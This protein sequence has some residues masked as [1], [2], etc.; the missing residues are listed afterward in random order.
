MRKYLEFC[1]L[2]ADIYDIIK[3]EVMIVRNYSIGKFADL[4]GVTPQT[5]RNWHK[6]GQ[7]VPAFISQGGTRYYSK[8]YN[9]WFKGSVVEKLKRL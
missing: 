5:L 7:L 8:D 3:H 9:K 4:I 2:C 6:E 1:S